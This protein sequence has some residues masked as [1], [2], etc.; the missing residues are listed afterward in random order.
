MKIVLYAV[1]LLFLIVFVVIFVG[2]LL[3]EKHVTSRKISLHRSPEEVFS[4][5]S[6]FQSEPSWR[7]D[8]QQVIMQPSKTGQVRF[9]E[10]S[11]NGSIPMELR[12]SN[13][14]QR[15]VIEI[16]DKSLPF[17]GLW[18]FDVAPAS[19][20]CTLQ[21]TERGEVHNPF[22]RFVSRFILGHRKTMDAY[23]QD[24]ASHF[25]ES[26]ALADSAPAEL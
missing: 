26:S 16:A 14:P 22:F 18:I 2:F 10:R 11:K 20:G 13:P 21:I 6:D 12:L 8:V 1:L 23:L 9:I 4:L 5:I 17:G 3:P 19:Q 25:H 15:L 24:V 7:R